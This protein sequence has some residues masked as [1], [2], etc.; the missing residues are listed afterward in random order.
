[1][2]TSGAS[3]ETSMT[4]VVIFIALTL[5]VFFTGGPRELLLALQRMVDAVG[6]FVF[7]T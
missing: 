5:L 6:N 7:A 1:M 4:V 2:R 3:T